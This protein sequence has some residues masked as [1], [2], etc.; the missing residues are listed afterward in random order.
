MKKMTR[1]ELKVKNVE[2]QTKIL[3]KDMNIEI[4]KKDLIKTRLRQK[5]YRNL[6]WIYGITAVFVV[7]VQAYGIYG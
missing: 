2:L 7:I 1:E 3:Q 6:T 4:L 5:T